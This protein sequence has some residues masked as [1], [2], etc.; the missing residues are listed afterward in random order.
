MAK[1]LKKFDPLSG[2]GLDRRIAGLLGFYDHSVSPSKMA[3]IV[4]DFISGYH[5]IK[6]HQPGV[7]VFGSARESLSPRMYREAE[8]LAKALAKK[9]YSVITGGGPGIMQAANRGA[10]SAKGKSVGLGIRLPWETGLN[11][12]L[13]D[14]ID[15][16]YFFARKVMLT[17]ASRIY[18][19]FPGGFGTLDELFEILTLT[20]TGRI[21]S[22]PIILVG[23]KFWQPLVK[24]FKESL[25]L[26]NRAISEKDLN[27]FCVADSA[28]E[29]LKQIQKLR[30]I[31]K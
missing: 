24:W 9:G 15:F 31:H 14:Q 8:K 6:H 29:A 26:E 10:H 18:V 19:F 1:T 11:S 22:L 12:Y 4:R 16:N 3:R 2:K 13:T 25:Y 30:K 21:H 7:T 28:K 23:K 20:Q 5:L 27:L 17:T